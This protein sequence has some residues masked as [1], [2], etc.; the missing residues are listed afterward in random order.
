MPIMIACSVFHLMLSSPPLPAS[1]HSP[2]PPAIHCL[3]V[4]GSE[5]RLDDSPVKGSKGQGKTK[6]KIKVPKEDKKKKQQQQQ[7]QQPE[8]SEKKNKQKIDEM[9]V[10]NLW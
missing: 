9:K 8:V 3:F 4:R 1:N 6:E 5:I 10:S 2:F 7:P